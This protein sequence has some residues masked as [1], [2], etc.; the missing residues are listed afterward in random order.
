M[1]K[2]F[3]SHASLLQFWSLLR[4]EPNAASRIYSCGVFFLIEPSTGDS[5]I[6]KVLKVSNC[7]NSKSI[8]MFSF[9]SF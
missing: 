1:Q 2:F 9:E 6:I 7:I 5:L 3:S 4:S 8:S